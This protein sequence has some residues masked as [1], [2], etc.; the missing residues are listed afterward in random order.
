MVSCGASFVYT[1]ERSQI[2]SVVA[3]WS[4]SC[5]Y[6]NEPSQ[7]RAKGCGKRLKGGKEK[8]LGKAKNSKTRRCNGC[9]LIGQSHDKRNCP[10]IVNMS[11]ASI[12]TPNKSSDECYSSTGNDNMPCILSIV[13]IHIYSLCNILHLLCFSLQVSLSDIVICLSSGTMQFGSL[14]L[15]SCCNVLSLG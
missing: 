5:N 1:G 3:S 10:M 11:F 6:Y 7:V 4:V 2:L 15:V 12:P 9:G 8:A 14:R 13:V